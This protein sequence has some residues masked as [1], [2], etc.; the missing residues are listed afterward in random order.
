MSK[1]SR[2]EEWS[3]YEEEDMDDEMDDEEDFS[4]TDSSNQLL[5]FI[6]ENFYHANPL[7]DEIPEQDRKKPK[8]V[9]SPNV[10]V[11]TP[12][13][14]FNLHD[15]IARRSPL[16]LNKM[17][18]CNKEMDCIVVDLTDGFPVKKEDLQ[19]GDIDIIFKY[20]YGEQVYSAH[21]FERMKVVFQ[22]VQYFELE[23]LRKLLESNLPT[24]TKME[25]KIETG[26]KLN[27]KELFNT[28]VELYSSGR[29]IKLVNEILQSDIALD[30][31][32]FI[33]RNKLKDGNKKAKKLTKEMLKPFETS[34]EVVKKDS[35]HIFTNGY[36]EML[37]NSEILELLEIDW[38][39]HLDSKSIHQVD[40]SF[41]ASQFLT[42]DADTKTSETLKLFGDGLSVKVSYDKKS[43][44]FRA[45]FANDF[46]QCSNKVKCTIHCSFDSGKNIFTRELYDGKKRDHVLF[47]HDKKYVHFQVWAI[48][49]YKH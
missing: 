16:I 12:I 2:K 25:L 35:Q 44:K 14:D 20:L 23:E 7:S 26:S 17:E 39:N 45:D 43:G 11:K 21:E 27:D 49:E 37:N 47:E 9:V 18:S 10:I 30:C 48:L 13:R 40:H 22:L 28:M 33:L 1:R 3:S 5:K 41:K 46:T 42:T 24:Q 6:R 38:N 36:Q 32:L 31:K 8:V 4:S 29:S 15:F 34:I 19:D